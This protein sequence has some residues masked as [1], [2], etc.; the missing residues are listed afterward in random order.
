MSEPLLRLEHIT[1]TFTVGDVEVRALRGV[2]LT[3]ERGEFVAIVGASGSGNS[4]LMSILG[5]LDRP[6]S[7]HYFFEG[8]DVGALH[9]P[10][11][12]RIRGDRIGFCVPE[13]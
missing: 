13:L 10:D 11:L 6:T 5:C 12:A 4:T 1:R 2:N 9:E 8:V 3:V 7:G